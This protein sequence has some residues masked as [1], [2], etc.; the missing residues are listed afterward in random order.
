MAGGT[1]LT[2]AKSMTMKR[3]PSSSLFA[4]AS[5]VLLGA[6]LS[7]GCD[8]G[9]DRASFASAGQ[10]VRS[11]GHP[12]VEDS[13]LIKFRDVPSRAALENILRRVDGKVQD[14]NGDGRDDLFA[15]IAGGRLAKVDLVGPMRAMQAL[16]ELG[17][18]PALEYAQPN[19]L[20][21]LD[22]TPNDPSFG[23]LWGLHNTGQSGGTAGADIS[24]T[25]AWDVTTGS[26]DVIVGV[27][28]TGVDYNHPDLAANIWTN[29][30]EIAGNGL[31]D[32]GNGY[33]DDIHGINAI[34]NS[35]NPMDDH[36][37]G[38]HVSGTIGAVGNNGVGVAGV[39]WSV[40]I[41]GM[42][43]LSSGGSGTTAD[44]IKCIDYAVALKQSGVNIRVLSNSWGGG[45]FEQ[46]LLD[47]INAANAVDILFVAAAGND[48]LNNDSSPHY[49]SSYDAPNVL[50]VASTD[51][52]DALSSFSN[53]GATS[54]DMGAPGSS[55]LSTVVG[56]GYASFSGTSMATPHV[57]GAA[58]LLLSYNDL[59]TV[60]DL[61]STLMNSG[62][63]IPA[64]SGKTVSGRRLNVDAALAQ[65]DPPA[66]TFRLDVSPSSQT[67]NQGQSTSFNLS[68][69]SV[70]GFSGD[71]ALSLSSSPALNAT[72]TFSPN[73]V[74]VGAGSVLIIDTT[75]ATATGTYSLTITGVSG[76]I[77]RT[78]TVS[79][80]VRP[81]GT[82]DVT[83]S[84]NTP[85]SI[86]DNVPAGV[87]STLN[88]TDVTVI[89]STSV[90][91]NITH[92]YIGDLIVK[93][94]SPIGTQA[95]LHNRAGGSADNLNQTYTVSAFNSENTYGAWV[96]S[97]S[98]NAGID[99]GT[100]DNWSLTFT[101]VPGGEP[102]NIPPTAD[103]TSSTSGLVAT[104]T[105]TSSDPDGTI[106]SWSWNFGDGNTST[107]QHPVHTYAAD[108]TYSV[109][110]TV[111]DDR[112]GQKTVTRSVTVVA[113]YFP[114]AATPASQTVSQGQNASYTVT[115]A[116]FEG[117]ASNVDLSLSASPALNATSDFTPNPV[118]AG[119]SSTL[120]V[121]TSTSTA[122]GT[123]TLTITGTSGAL[124][125]T[126]TVTLTVWPEGASASTY[127]NNTPVSIPDYTPAGIT[128]TIV[129]PSSGTILDLEVTVNIT[130]TYIG[131]LIV[132]LT[133]PAGT[134]VTL[135]NRAGGGAD[136]L[137]TT[138]YPANFDG[139]NQAGSWTLS[140]S[141]NAN[142]DVGTL[143]N[144]SLTITSSGA[145]PPPPPGAISLSIT[146]QEVK[147]KSYKVG[148]G[149]S[150][151][152]GGNVDLY[153]NGALLATPSNSGA[154]T[155]TVDKS[156]G[157]SFSYVVCEVGSTT[158]CSNTAT[159]TF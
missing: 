19:Y 4:S 86:P 72:T 118:A 25:S 59:L 52:N 111:T 142:L 14:A 44:A 149:W 2:R 38:T 156:A 102:G 63:A 65:T 134:Q 144:W 8:G 112:G 18:H 37:H 100:L 92:T 79:L 6:L 139:E 1:I 56:G 45:G 85:V 77:T 87:T 74:A 64:L 151:A 35:G 128:S 39:N 54:V 50:A 105:D 60:A 78:K 135:H 41:I 132:K 66:P 82:I 43:F 146:S 148:L 104:F 119:G 42:K 75:T 76:S 124:T 3:Y 141:D 101:G 58:T 94:T 12:F 120:T 108:G 27:I 116:G 17:N 109:S 113:P 28:D 32:D 154:Y 23:D 47:A 157:T 95:V 70:L 127:S 67:L 57:S 55:I 73:P 16:A 145:P 150:G 61:K 147:G 24:A 153:R 22:L 7:S 125:K 126:A 83:Y 110:L 49:P 136:N 138:Y 140:V 89:S 81:E 155:D 88:V 131:D 114:L 123:Y 46:A 69:T 20:H 62:D 48:S 121:A 93:L 117:F 133:S 33:V 53:Y 29:P 115:V 11:N 130:H 36:D 96:L 137:Y 31:D 21:F 15:H 90:T 13:I 106:A 103:F 122:T 68:T 129:V 98:D 51:R 159:A 34:T 107:A 91:V 80:V 5:I 99:V 71:V 84:N 97:V 158:A 30:N 152:T 10:A 143:D 26:S 40:S 9:A